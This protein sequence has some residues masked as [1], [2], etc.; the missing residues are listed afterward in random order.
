[1]D[2]TA[3][4]RFVETNVDWPVSNRFVIPM[5]GLLSFLQ[6]NLRFK[7]FLVAMP[8]F[9][10]A[11]AADTVKSLTTPHRDQLRR[12]VRDIVRHMFF[13]AQIRQNEFRIEYTPPAVPAEAAWMFHVILVLLVVVG[14]EGED[15]RVADSPDDALADA[16]KYNAMIAHWYEQ[17]ARPDGGSETLR[18]E[19]VKVRSPCERKPHLPAL[20]RV[21]VRPKSL[22]VAA[23]IAAAA[24]LAHR[25]A[26][27]VPTR[28]SMRVLAGKIAAGVD[29]GDEFFLS[30][31]ERA[32]SE[33][34]YSSLPELMSVSASADSESD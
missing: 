11:Y 33:V 5:G 22:A 31:E 17:G 21:F 9:V 23:G 27:R 16:F 24:D 20:C 10:D 13:A 6:T 32:L 8:V 30:K 12:R 4:C 19:P 1:M 18:R 7:V 26:K 34:S 29:G 14:F 3:L 28:R 15:N 25:A 2:A